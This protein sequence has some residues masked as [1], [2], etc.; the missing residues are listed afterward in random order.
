MHERFVVHT[1]GRESVNNVSILL[2]CLVQF[3]GGGSLGVFWAKHHYI[4]IAVKVS[5]RVAFDEIF[6]KLYIFNSFY[7]LD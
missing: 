2:I 5:F 4:Y 7:L 3:R 6:K 1:S